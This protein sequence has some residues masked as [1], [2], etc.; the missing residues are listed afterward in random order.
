DVTWR[1]PSYDARTATPG[2]LNVSR[3][4]R[5]C[6]QSSV[7]CQAGCC[8]LF[9]LQ[10]GLGSPSYICH[11]IFRSMPITQENDSSKTSFVRYCREVDLA[12]RQVERARLRLAAKRFISRCAL[13]A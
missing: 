10:D 3:M 5:A 1:G 4:G 2:Q 13:Q 9:G 6:S 12:A 7:F 8:R 11:S